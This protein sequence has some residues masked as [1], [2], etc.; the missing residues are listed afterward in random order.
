MNEYRLFLSM[1]SR[2]TPSR[3]VLYVDDE[4]SAQEFIE[5]AEGIYELKK[6]SVEET[7]EDF[8]GKIGLRFSRLETEL[9]EKK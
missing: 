6:L 7:P 9:G 3:G 2:V 5:A 4:K 8:K 1:I